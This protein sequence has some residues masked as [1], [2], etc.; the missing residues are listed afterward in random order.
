M[1]LDVV[2]DAVKL[3][4]RFGRLRIEINITREVK[5]GHLVETLYHDGTRLSLPY[6]AQHLSMTFLAKDDNLPS[7][8]LILFFDTLLELEHH[9]TGRID[10]LDVIPTSEFVGL[11]GLTMSTQQ[12]FHIVEFTHLFMVDGD[13]PHLAQAFTLHPIVYNITK[14]IE[15]LTLCKFLFGFLDGCGHTETETTA[16]IDFNLYHFLSSSK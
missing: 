3:V 10:D 5:S 9:R 2:D 15:R 14:T 13:K 7:A 16:A 8:C 6:K 4:K 12:H 11:W 1:R